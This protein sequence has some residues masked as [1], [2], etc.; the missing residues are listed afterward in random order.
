MASLEQGAE[1]AGEDQCES[2]V[3][4]DRRSAEEAVEADEAGEAEHGGDVAVGLGAN[5]IESV[6]E[7]G[8]GEAALEEEA[9]AVDDVGRQ[10]GEVGEGA[11]LDF[12]V[13][14]VGLAQEDGGRRVAVGDVLDVHDYRTIGKIST[15]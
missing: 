6:V 13:L 5:D 8:E 3:A 1:E 15:L 2:A 12:A 9:Q 4:Q 7:G 11:F 10:L 14:A